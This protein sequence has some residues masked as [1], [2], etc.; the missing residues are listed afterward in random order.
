MD[1]HQEISHAN[2]K[3]YPGSLHETIFIVYFIASLMF[4]TRVIDQ[5]TSS[6][7]HP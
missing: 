7:M 3:T 6:T 1:G 4:R 2:L 5:L